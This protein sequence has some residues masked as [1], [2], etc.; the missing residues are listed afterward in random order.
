MN[1]VFLDL[2]GTLV[3]SQGRLYRL[4][5]ELC[6]ECG[7]SYA[8][9]WTLKRRRMSQKEMLKR[10]FGYSDDSVIRFHKDWMAHVEDDDAVLTDSP[11]EGISDRLAAMAQRHSLYLVTARQKP[12]LVGRQIDRF[13]WRSYFRDLVVTRQECG[14]CAAIRAVVG[15][16]AG[17]IMIGDTG[18]DVKTAREL[19]FR[20]VAVGWGILSPD[21]LR[22]YNPDYLAER[23]E[24]LDNCPFI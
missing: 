8:E 2:D 10:F 24:D 15:H 20:S 12:E 16:V 9:Y 3:N 6:P 7:M 4:F 14:K 22:E 17:G 23:M 5:R 19:G 21:V 13:G 18:D 1:D 11:V